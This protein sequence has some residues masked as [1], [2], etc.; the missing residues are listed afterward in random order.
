VEAVA[1]LSGGANTINIVGEVRSKSEASILAQANGVVEAVHTT[2]GASVPAGYVLAE[3]EN[4]SQAAAVLQAEGAYEAALA[5][6]HAVSA[7]SAPID[8]NNTYHTAFSSLE[9]TL[10]VYVDSFFGTQ[11]A[12][13]PQ[14]LITPGPT[15][16]GDLSKKRAAI[17][18]LM[19]DWRSSLPT[20]TAKDPMQL[21]AEAESTT[22]AVSI[23]LD[24]LA[25]AAFD[26]SS[27]AT[28]TQ[29]AD[30]ATAR[31]AVST[32]R[33]TIAA[34][35][36]SYRSGSVS[37][38]ASVD[39]SVKSAL[40]S[41]RAAQANLEKTLVRAPISGTVNFFSVRV[42]DYVTALSHVATVAQNGALEIVAYASG[43]NR[44]LLFSGEK[45]DIEGDG[46]GVVTSVS[47]AL[48][49]ETKQIEVHIAVDA[50]STLENGQSVSV[51][52]KS[53]PTAAT[54][55]GPLLLPLT[56][57]KLT[58]SAR[59]VFSVGADG[60]LVSHPVEIGD[61]HGDRIEVR[62]ALPGDLM[63]VKDARGLS[64]GEKVTVVP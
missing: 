44:D 39:A 4:S 38:T 15:P 42:G 27:T 1:S 24:E 23:F 28:A 30:L 12:T 9:T 50:P 59:V 54:T 52:L 10:A 61:V 7:N 20:S 62:T 29:L 14:L 18:A 47:P 57:L 5:S 43:D 13:G 19:N 33:A 58:P 37:S 25:T 32:L 60:R 48:N 55:T 8:A 21:L 63:I 51:V 53:A 45:V 22:Q 36:N 3:L 16:T 17:T 31:S 6:Q 34:A 2:L 41:L 64:D 49:P 11:Q 35:E 56:A 26:P 40:G 46:H